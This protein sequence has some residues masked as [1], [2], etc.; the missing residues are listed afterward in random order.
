[1]PANTTTEADSAGTGSDTGDATTDGSTLAWGTT[2]FEPGGDVA[3]VGRWTVGL[4]ERGNPSTRERLWSLVA[5]DAPLDDILDEL[6]SSGL[7]ALPDFGLAQVEGAAVRIVARGRTTITA[8]RSSGGDHEIDPSGVRTW[9]EELVADVSAITI[10][11]P[12]PDDPAPSTEQFAVLAGSVPARSLSR[13]YDVP[14]D[15]AA[16]AESGAGWTAAAATPSA[17]GSEQPSTPPSTSPSTSPNAPSNATA[18]PSDDEVAPASAAEPETIDGIGEPGSAP[19][20]PWSDDRDGDHPTISTTPG[21]P[22]GA[23]AG[24]TATDAASVDVAPVDAAPVGARP[25]SPQPPPPGWAPSPPPPG[26]PVPVGS[27]PFDPSSRGSESE[28]SGI[29]SPEAGPVDPI[30]DGGRDRSD[31]SDDDG[32]APTPD[33]AGDDA[34]A[35][36]PVFSVLAF[37]NGERVVVDRAVLIGR[38]PKVAGAVDGGPPHIM[39]F[40]GPGQGLSRTHAEVRIE[41]GNVVIEDLQSTNGTEV[42]LPGQ[43][44]RRLRGGEPVVIVPGALID[45][46]DELHCTLEASG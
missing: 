7:K 15:H 45:F 38:N 16:A 40:D 5:D 19:D 37:S 27:P 8:E 41:A 9:I 39:K 32:G 33:G 42:Q 18:V 43:Q 44:R 25:A 22:D 23:S 14:D 12:A 6:S 3:L 34:D 36:A 1:M 29:G 20:G 31:D 2:S 17:G 11:L 35:D 24:P 10:A 46:G 13:R 28:V 4:V 21:D 26:G 30:F